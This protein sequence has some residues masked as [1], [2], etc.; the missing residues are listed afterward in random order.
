MGALNYLAMVIFVV[1]FLGIGFAIYSDYQRGALEREFEAKAQDLAERVNLM[2]A[3]DVGATDYL[4]IYVPPNCQL[5][6]SDNAV[7][8]R[9]GGSSRSFPV[10]V[11]VQEP[12]P[13]FG[14]QR[15][16][17]VIQRTPAGVSLSVA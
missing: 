4:E 6:F 7:L 5:S 14:N 12:V 2:G 15:V 1:L 11:S 3:Q 13:V 9:I 17:L 10:S 16:N 8:V